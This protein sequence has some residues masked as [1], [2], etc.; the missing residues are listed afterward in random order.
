MI[1]SKK[2]DEKVRK[3]NLVEVKVVHRPMVRETLR[4]IEVG[5]TARF[6][7]RQLGGSEAT[8]RSAV[9]RMKNDGEALFSVT[10]LD[11]HNAFEITRLK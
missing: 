7:R 2:D 9:S 11:F 1:N 8:L 4:L 10:P 6:S 3:P 5:Q